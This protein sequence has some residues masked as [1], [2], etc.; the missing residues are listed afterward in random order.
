MQCC[1]DANVKAGGA[2]TYVEEPTLAGALADPLVR[3]VMAA[4]GVDAKQLETMLVS[5]ARTFDRQA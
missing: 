5:I 1:I 2:R 3:A 4:D